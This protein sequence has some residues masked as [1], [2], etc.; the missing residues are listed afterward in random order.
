MC[1]LTKKEMIKNLVLRLG[2]YSGESIGFDDKR[3]KLSPSSV[4]S[5][6]KKSVEIIQRKRESSK[7][8]LKNDNQ[9]NIQ[10]NLTREKSSLDKLQFKIAQRQYNQLIWKKIKKGLMFFRR[11][12]KDY[13]IKKLKARLRLQI[14]K[15]GSVIARSLLDRS[16]S[17][18]FD[19]T[20]LDS[21]DILKLPP[22]MKNLILDPPYV[23]TI[24]IQ[25]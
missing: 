19:K 21:V 9:K 3:S 15:F 22:P 13:S 10:T 16:G 11:T 4:Y 1:G 8:L 5:S 6:Q 23:V 12:N 7:I 17:E 14:D 24:L 20:I 2:N 25:P 18:K